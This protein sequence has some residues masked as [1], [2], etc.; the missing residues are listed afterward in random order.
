MK[1]PVVV[2]SHCPQKSARVRLLAGMEAAS[3]AAAND[4]ARKDKGA[5]DF[6]IGVD[7]CRQAVIL[8]DRSG[9]RSHKM[10]LGPSDV[11]IPISTKLIS[12]RFRQTTVSCFAVPYGARSPVSYWDMV[13]GHA[14]PTVTL[15]GTP[16]AGKSKSLPGGGDQP[17]LGMSIGD[18][19]SY[20]AHVPGHC[21]QISARLKPCFV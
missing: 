18:H 20:G 9:N 2:V 14:H 1:S 16:Q 6:I 17:D 5:K 21:G 4:R 7:E 13:S 12:D 3:P 11:F 8:V 10:K 15:T 19:R